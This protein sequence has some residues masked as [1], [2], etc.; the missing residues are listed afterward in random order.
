MK[1]FRCVMNSSPDP[2]TQQITATHIRLGTRL[3]G[4]GGGGGE[5]GTITHVD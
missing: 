3:T 1:T 5:G 4:G 2:N